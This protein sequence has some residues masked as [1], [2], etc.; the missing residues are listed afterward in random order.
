MKFAVVSDIHSNL[1]A[2]HAAEEVINEND[3]EMVVC[4]GDIIGYGAFPNECC[5]IVRKLAGYCV[6][7]NHEVSALTRDTI[8]MNP[9][10]AKASTWTSEVLNQDSRDYLLTIEQCAKFESSGARVAMYH[11]STE[12]VV[13]YVYED[14]TRGSMLSSVDADI[15]ILGHTH[16]PYM[17]KFGSGL[18]VNPGSIGQPR[19]GD[20][21]GSL[22][23]IDSG[24]RV[25]SIIR[26]DYDIES[27]WTAIVSA[28]LPD[29]LGERLFIGR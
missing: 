10:A 29:Y 14:D 18:I 13:E 26:F 27:A 21:R 1:H 3:V 12:S 7:G 28:G 17:R 22:A 8:W 24:A 15:L 9:H 16:I 5:E 4:A 23:I 19:D 6:F 25:C 2:L 11:G 20:P